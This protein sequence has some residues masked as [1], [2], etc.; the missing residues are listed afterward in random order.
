[1]KSRERKGGRI[2]VLN[3]SGDDDKVK[4]NA[5]GMEYEEVEIWSEE[6]Q[7]NICGLPQKRSRSRSRS[8]REDDEKDRPTKAPR[9]QEATKG[10]KGKGRGKRPSDPCWMC[11]R[12][13]FQRECTNLGKGGSPYP[14]TTAWTSWRPGS[15]PGPT[16]AHG[17]LGFPSHTKNKERE[18]AKVKEKE[19]KATKEKERDNFL[20]LVSIQLGD[21]H[22]ATCRIGTRTV[23][24]R[25]GPTVCNGA[26][27][28]QRGRARVEEGKKAEKRPT[29]R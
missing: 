19:E 27:C 21:R 26:E 11:G 18:R 5:D 20:D 24:V 10:D 13:H 8:R 1:M 14:I 17:T 29:H 22:L 2:N 4:C 15:F 23:P 6:W 16:P 7:C 28:I 25:V 3:S 9:D 12:P